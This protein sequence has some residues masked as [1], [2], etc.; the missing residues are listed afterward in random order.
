MYC[1]CYCKNK[2]DLVYISNYYPQSPL[3]LVQKLDKQIFKKFHSNIFNTVITGREYK[4]IEKINIVSR[5][6]KE[7]SKLKRG[8]ELGK[9]TIKKNKGGVKTLIGE[10]LTRYCINYQKT[11]CSKDEKEI[12]R[13]QDF[14]NVKKILIRRVANNVL[15]TYDEKNY[16]F[17]KNL[18]SL[19]VIGCEYNLKFVLG[20]LN[21]KVI[22]FY[23]IKYF[24]TKKEEIFPEIQVYQLQKLPIPNLDL[25]NPTQKSQHDRMVQLVDQMLDT[26]KQSLHKAKSEQDRKHYQQRADILRR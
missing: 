23:F 11:F 16:F 3:T 7:I 14:S 25:S 22:S 18:Y 21:S 24:T 4:V 15:A 17:I 26:Q 20:V 6:L 10:D 12:K 9:K 5:Q 8:M 2:N 19:V 1:I 13:L